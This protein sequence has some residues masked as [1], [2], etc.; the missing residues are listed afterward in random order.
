MGATSSAV[1]TSRNHRGPAGWLCMGDRHPPMESLRVTQSL[2]NPSVRGLGDIEKTVV[3]EEMLCSTLCNPA[4]F[5]PGQDAIQQRA[6]ENIIPET[7][8]IHDDRTN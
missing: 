5:K 1:G 8:I 2:Q 7:I 4:K 6:I 3:M